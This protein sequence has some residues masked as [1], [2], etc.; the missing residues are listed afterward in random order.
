MT[1]RQ[2]LARLDSGR[3]RMAMVVATGVILVLVAWE[4]VD[5]WRYFS[6]RGEL[7][8]DWVF[9]VKLGHRWL[10]TGVIYGDRQLT[11]Q[12]YHVLVND[13]NQYPPTSILLFAAFAVVPP[14]ISALIWWVA[15]IAAVVYAVIHLRPSAWTWPVIAFCVFWPRTIGSLIVGNSDLVSAGF[16]AGG[17]LWGWPGALGFF[18]PSFA[19]FG[20]VGARRRSWWIALAAGLAL[21]VPFL[22]NGAWADYLTAVRNWDLPWDRAILNIPLLLIPIVAWL[23]RRDRSLSSED[24][25]EAGT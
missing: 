18:K 12:P 13:D 23:G 21:S 17:I 1:L 15:P 16:V 9:Y 6:G 3:G 8:Q 14:L 7:A 11:G 25:G 5:L 2:R 19:P 4:A 22:L 20:L 10:D 24:I